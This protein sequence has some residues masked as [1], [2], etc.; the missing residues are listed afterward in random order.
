MQNQRIY[1]RQKIYRCLS[2]YLPSNDIQQAHRSTNF[3]KQIEKAFLETAF[4]NPAL[5]K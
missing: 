3:S 1:L 5:L 2:K 4:K